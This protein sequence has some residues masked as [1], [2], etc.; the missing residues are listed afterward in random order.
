VAQ[1]AG[2]INYEVTTRIHPDV[3]RLMAWPGG[4]LTWAEANSPDH[5]AGAPPPLELG[6]SAT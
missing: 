2:T 5:A 6:D 1:R 3:P 4:R